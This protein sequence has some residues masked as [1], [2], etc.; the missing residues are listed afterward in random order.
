MVYDILLMVYCFAQK[1]TVYKYLMHVLYI[2]RM[3]TVSFLGTY[4]FILFYFCF[5][6]KTNVS[7]NFKLNKKKKSRFGDTWLFFEGSIEIIS[8]FKHTQ[9]EQN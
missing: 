4:G 7:T 3:Y 6:Q 8:N 1:V 5:F 2:E 9:N